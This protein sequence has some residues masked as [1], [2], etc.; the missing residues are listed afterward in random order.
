MNEIDVAII[1]GGPA[2]LQAAL[3]LARTR[4]RVVVFDSPAPPRNNASHGIHNFLGLEGVLPSQLRNVAWEQIARYGTA[5]LE[6]AEVT[7]VSE[8]STPAGH[9]LIVTTDKGAWSARHVLLAVGYRDLYPNVPGF[10]ECWG[11]TIIPCPFCDG[12]EN[13]DRNWGIVASSPMELDIFPRMVQNWTTERCVIASPDLVMTPEQ[14]EALDRAG[15]SLHRGSIV[16]LDH[17]HGELERVALDDGSV[18]DVGTLLWSPKEEATPLIAR[19]VVDLGL[20]LDANGYVAVNEMQQTST[21]GLWAA[22]DVQGW[23][24]AIEAANQ[25]GMAATMIVHGWFEG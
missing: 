7:Q 5:Q 6:T 12:F 14:V 4:K 20:A 9:R 13:R 23:Q 25:G 16:A 11:H 24:G 8:V 17:T 1:G 21:P 2:G 22:G 19:L 3:V 15:V 10:S 18:I